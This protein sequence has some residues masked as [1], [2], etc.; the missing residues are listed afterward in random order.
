M[1]EPVEIKHG[2]RFTSYQQE[3]V[4]MGAHT[5]YV[6]KTDPKHILFMMARYKFVSKLLHGK[7]KVLEIGC[8]DA[9]PSVIVAQEVKILDCINQEPLFEKDNREWLKFFNNITFNVHDIVKDPLNDNY[10]AG[11]S[12]DVLEHINPNDE[13]IFF[14]NI[15][16]ALK[17]EGVL[18]IGTP[19]KDAAKY[20]SAYSNKTHVNLKNYN[21]LKDIM[22][23][24]FR[25]CLFF[26]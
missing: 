1:S 21:E 15:C 8:G 10:D 25:N 16:K 4:K 18:V 24:R 12:L 23:E 22:G 26:R 5:T 2:V 11:Y 7:N 6:W 20:A 17:P 14:L 19:N 13:E 9:F 3:P